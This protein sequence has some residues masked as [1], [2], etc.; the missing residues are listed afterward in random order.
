MNLKNKLAGIVAGAAA[1]L[2]LATTATA[3]V[4]ADALLDKL[5]A[6]GILKQDEAEQLKAESITNN[7]EGHTNWEHINFKISKVVKSME[8]YGDLRMRYE[9]RS[10]QLEPGAGAAYDTADRW[11]YAVRIGVRGDLTNDFYYGLRLETSQNERS[12]WNTFGGSSSSPYNGPFSK[13]SD[14]IYIGQ[15]Y[16][17]WRPAS[18]LDVSVGRVP[19]P[20]Y[21]T[22]MVWDSDYT[23]EGVVEKLKFT[24]GPVDYF[25]TL[26]QYVYQDVTPT[27]AAAVEGGSTSSGFLGNYSDQ[28]AYLLAWQ[29]G[30]TYHLDTNVSFKVAP[31][32]YSYVGHGNSSAGFYGPFVGQGIGGWTYSTT[33]SPTS[34]NTTASSIPGSGVPGSSTYGESY[35][36][37]GINN[38][39][40]IEFPMELNFKLWR[41]D[42]KLFGDYSL[43]LQGD[44]RARAAYAAGG[45]A[46]FPGGVQLDQAQAMQF[47]LAVGN[48]LGLV[49]GTTSKKGTWEARAYWQHVEQYALDP[50]LLDSDFFEGRGN[51][52]GLYAALAYS[53]TDAMIGTVRYG[54]AERIDNQLGTGGYNADLPLPNPINRFQMMQADL[55]LRF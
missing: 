30:L 52:Q 9:Y 10:A 37:T 6:K 55:T 5:V 16:L 51:L 28:N 22:S 46:A 23:P 27:S 2:A 53:F 31:V 19:Q 29:L 39:E 44:D 3:Q 43:N 7:A 8:L 12:T 42:A 48:N 18:W 20:L 15:A 45:A 47:G 13:S 50:N 54:V 17:G 11:R 14:S 35:N 21:T 38:L 24:H 26:G 32:L 40:I 1:C 36:Q 25:T 33:F 41:L 34:P 4:S 49:Y